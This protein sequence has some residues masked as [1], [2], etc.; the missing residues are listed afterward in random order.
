M[1]RSWKL[2]IR[3]LHSGHKAEL[4]GSGPGCEQYNRVCVGGVGGGGMMKLE[5]LS[6]A[7]LEKD[8]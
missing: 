1:R 5:K 4:T 8:T 3:F 6:P 2:K 7:E